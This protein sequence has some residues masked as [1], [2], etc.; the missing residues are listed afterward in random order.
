[1]R[2]LRLLLLTLAAVLV[3]AVPAAAVPPRTPPPAARIIAGHTPSQAWPAQT[4]VIF[5]LGGSQFVCGGTLVSARWVLT[6]GHCATDDLG[7]ALAPTAFELNV[8]GTTRDNGTPAAVDQVAVEPDFTPEMTTTQNVPP[9]NDLTLLHLTNPVAQEPLRLVGTD[10]AD[11]ALWGP[12]VPATIIGWGLTEANVQ[13]TFLREAQAPMVSD[14]SCL[15]FWGPLFDS[16]SMVC[17][18]G[19]SSDTCG[20]DSGGP[21]MVARGGSFMLVGVTSWGAGNPCGQAG[22]PGG[23]ARV[24]APALNTW[25]RSIVPATDLAVNPATPAPGEPVRL[26][27]T[28]ALGAHTT[29]PTAI[30]WDL[31][32]DGA[33]DDA[34][35]SVAEATFAGIGDH[36]VRVQALFSDGDRAVTREV[37]PVAEPAPPVTPPVTPPAT[38]PPVTAAPAPQATPAQIQEVQRLLAPALI[39]TV[40]VPARVKLRALRG[41]SLRVSFR[42]ER[43]CTISGRMTL[44][45]ATARRYGL[46]SG[47]TIGRGSGSR[48][49]GG[50]STMT[51]RLTSRAKRALRNRGGFAVRLATDLSGAGAIAVRG[52]HRIAVSR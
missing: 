44:D 4:S 32:A 14:A 47:E 6:A 26:T 27:A 33:F 30:S 39:G 51:V 48:V 52:T 13:S 1:M 37:V 12:G 15:D 21:L 28:V 9:T 41:S 38:A 49:S 7:N 3:A 50:T 24:G 17:A 11:A 25:V 2:S 5:T 40:T 8:G 36:V 22:A 29:P 16:A 35:G 19:G 20:G 43:A 31:D 34:T 10:S 42:C 45:S 23:Y 18:G 46:R